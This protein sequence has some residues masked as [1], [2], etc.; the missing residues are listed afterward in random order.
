MG[1]L[2][3]VA[4]CGRNQKWCNKGRLVLGFKPRCGSHAGSFW[5]S[6]SL[7]RGEPQTSIS[8]SEVWYPGL[9]RR[10]RKGCVFVGI[11]KDFS[12]LMKTLSHYSSVCVTL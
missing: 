3:A 6:L 10:G 1:M 12:I 8:F 5:G 7:G 4:N 11:L 9:G 2:V